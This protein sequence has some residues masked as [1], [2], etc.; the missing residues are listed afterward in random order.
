MAEKIYKM[1]SEKW[2]PETGAHF[3]FDGYSKIG[4]PK[5]CNNV[6]L[7]CLVFSYICQYSK[8]IISPLYL[9]QPNMLKCKV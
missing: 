3:K 5:G 4:L 7:V 2:N 6:H 8:Y 9:F 1:N